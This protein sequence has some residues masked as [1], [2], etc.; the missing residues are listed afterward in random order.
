MTKKY[1]NFQKYSVL[2]LIH[3]EEVIFELCAQDGSLT[4]TNKFYLGKF[5]HANWLNYSASLNKQVV[6]RLALPNL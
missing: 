3:H 4:Q 1:H 6:K 5:S 2:V